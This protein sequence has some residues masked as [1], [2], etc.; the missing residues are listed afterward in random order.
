M[1]LIVALLLAFV[2]HRPALPPP[3]TEWSVIE[4]LVP[5]HPV[6]PSGDKCVWV[7]FVVHTAGR[8][9]GPEG[10]KPELPTG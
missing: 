7:T 10:E 1:S 6:P 4:V 3:L 2:D 8:T 5:H 9:P